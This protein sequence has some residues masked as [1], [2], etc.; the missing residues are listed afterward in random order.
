MAII[1]IPRILKDLN[2]FFVGFGFAGLVND[3]TLPVLETKNEEHQGGGM[4]API[5]IEVGINKLDITFTLAEHDPVFLRNF[6]IS[7]NALKQGRF[8]GNLVGQNDVKKVEVQFTGRITKIDYGTVKGNQ[9][10]PMTVTMNLSY[11][12]YLYDNASVWEEDIP[13]F[14]RRVNGVDQLAVRRANLVN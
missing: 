10:N 2:L 5:D 7:V 13:N 9:L 6:G 11:Y 8:V 12:N 14:I 4:D 1:A 3:I